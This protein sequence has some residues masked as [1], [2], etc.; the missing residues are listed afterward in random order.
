MVLPSESCDSGLHAVR[1]CMLAAHSRNRTWIVCVP[2]RASLF[3][4]C[5]LVYYELFRHLGCGLQSRSL[6]ACEDLRQC[7]ELYSKFNRKHLFLPGTDTSDDL[8]W[9][10]DRQEA[11]CNEQ[12]CIFGACSA[13]LRCGLSSRAACG[14]ENIVRS[15][16]VIERRYFCRNAHISRFALACSIESLR[17]LTYNAPDR[18]QRS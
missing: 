8:H 7:H 2:R 17:A 16:A 6:A 5:L 13:Y 3:S 9:R 18:L 12:C 11:C 14:E 10:R 4:H 1:L 15:V